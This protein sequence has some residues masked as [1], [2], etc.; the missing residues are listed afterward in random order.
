MALDMTAQKLD[1]ALAANLDIDSPK[2][3]KDFSEAFAAE[4]M[5]RQEPAAIAWTASLLAI[6]YQ[7]LLIDWAQ[8]R[9]ILLGEDETLVHIEQPER[10]AALFNTQP[11][12]ED[13]TSARTVT[14]P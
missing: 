11:P 4:L 10:R 2:G 9:G 6:R 7:E 8:L 1:Q 14:H 5:F 3:A 13:E 12:S